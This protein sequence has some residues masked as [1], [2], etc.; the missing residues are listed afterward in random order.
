MEDVL[1]RLSGGIS[2]GLDPLCGFHALVNSL[3][4]DAG[5]DQEMHDVNVLR[6]E[7][8]R[9]RLGHALEV[10]TSL[11]KMPQTPGRHARWPS[12]P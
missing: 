5:V 2:L 8:A 7:F 12:H 1:V 3:A 4:V 9:H 6:S 11:M 10:R